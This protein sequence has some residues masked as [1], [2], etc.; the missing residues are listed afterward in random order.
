[1]TAA[2]DQPDE[3]PARY[4]REVGRLQRVLIANRGEIAIRIARAADA[5][6]MTSVA[7]WSDVDERAL[8]TRMATEAVR[9]GAPGDAVAAYL[10]ID[11]L[12]RAALDA[13]C[14][15]VHPG[16]GFLAENAGFAAACAAA[17]LTFV[18]PSADALALF[19]DKVRARALAASL[20][21]PI[22]AGSEGAV[23]TVEAAAEVAESIGYPVML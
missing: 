3:R 9:I 16:Y 18:G 17:G 2:P 11:G 5:V 7:V 4:D 1:M 6:G 19:G 23:D 14:D 10:D 13:G 22:V 8:H 15:C 21:I 20:D 12:V